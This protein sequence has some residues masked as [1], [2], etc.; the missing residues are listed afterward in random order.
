MVALKVSQV[1]EMKEYQ[2]DQSKAR[3]MEL[4]WFAEKELMLVQSG[5]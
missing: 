5:D 1:V 4:T 3:R 2:M